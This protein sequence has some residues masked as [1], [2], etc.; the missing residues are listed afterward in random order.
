[1]AGPRKQRGVR[2][3]PHTQVATPLPWPSTREGSAAA[4]DVAGLSP[5]SARGA[6]A[7][8]TAV[9]RIL[10]AG[11]GYGN[12]RD[13]SAGPALVER[14]RR[15][16]WPAS[17]QVEDLSF[18]AVHALHWFQQGPPFDAVVFLTAALRGREPGSVRRYAWSAPSLAAEEVQTRVA[19]AVTG[20][21]DLDT[22]LTVVGYFGALPPRV[23]V[24]EIEPRDHDWGPAF[25][26]PVEAALGRVEALVEQEVRGL[27]A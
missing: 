27:L 23:S 25:S 21:I 16:A 24:I 4:R 26:P 17:V 11:V 13:L 14:L 18:G 3:E 7:S 22:L 20:V 6:E 15:K 5:A 1:M 9:K 2:V 10:V 8:C 12:L 19:E